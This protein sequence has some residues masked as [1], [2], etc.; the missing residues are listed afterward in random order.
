MLT[1][2]VFRLTALRA[3]STTP[4]TL[5]A[6]FGLHN[7]PLSGSP[8]VLPPLAASHDS[9]PSPP[10]PFPSALSHHLSHIHHG[11]RLC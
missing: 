6:A 11:R 10:R 5:V 1:R 2:V 3:P 8:P 7:F 4:H 9:I